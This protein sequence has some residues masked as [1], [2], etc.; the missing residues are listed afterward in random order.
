MIKL[1]PVRHSPKEV[2]QVEKEIFDA[3]VKKIY[4]PL[5][6]TIGFKKKIFK[7][8]RSDLIEAIQSGQIVYSNGKFSGQFNSTLSRGLQELGAKWDRKHGSWTIPLPKLPIDIKN[9][10][11]LSEAKFVEKINQLNK[12]LKEFDAEKFA[13]EI[14]VSK[15]FDTALFKVDRN[16]S[17][18]VRKITVQPEISPRAREAI[19]REY[20]NNLKKYIKNFTV[21]EIQK[22][23]SKVNDS[24]YA[25]NRYETLIK[26]IQESYGVSQ[27]KAKFLARQETN[28][29]TAKF[30]E[31]R[32][33]DA[34]VDQ[35]E[36][37]CVV[38]SPNHPVRPLHKIH[39][40][41]IYSWD[42]PPIVDEKGNRKHPGEDY[43]CRCI[44]IP[45]VNFK[46]LNK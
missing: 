23:R 11:S 41:K 24:V 43:N 6:A 26:S 46:N 5:I 10:I 36:W 13:E 27:N 20:N 9:A 31:E 44:A 29:M 22:L 21:E 42:K 38:G 16:I 14:D 7:N 37:R 12:K 4:L 8:S 15:I 19:A 45:V 18:A 28:L 2:E 33:K 32:Y 39:D 1:K 17:E 40:G 30:R 25:G 34:G 35:Y 3:F